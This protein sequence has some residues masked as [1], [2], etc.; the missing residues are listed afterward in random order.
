MHVVLTYS[1]SSCQWHFGELPPQ[2]VEAA[3]CLGGENGRLENLSPQARRKQAAF[4]RERGLS[5]RR[6]C[7]L[8]RFARS[9]LGYELRLP[10]KNGPVIEAKKQLSSQYPRYGYR[11]IRILLKRQGHQLGRH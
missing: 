9:T 6:H 2:D 3:S 5:E 8:L 10:V 1:D 11:S 4:A 7:G